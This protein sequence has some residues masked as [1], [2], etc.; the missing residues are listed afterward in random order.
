MSVLWVYYFNNIY[1]GMKGEELARQFPGQLS[2]F[3]FGVFLTTNKM[4]VK[5]I[6]Y[7]SLSSVA[8][9]FMIKNTDAKIIIDPIAYSSIVIY[10]SSQAFKNINFG[11]YGDISYGIYL[12]HFPIIQSLISLGVF[13]YNPWLGLTAT[14]TLTLIAALASWHLIEKRMLKRTSHYRLDAIT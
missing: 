3:A 2:Y 14:F 10:L 9:L 7:I 5:N 6:K 4:T 13:Q 8:V 1:T 12:Y 11:K